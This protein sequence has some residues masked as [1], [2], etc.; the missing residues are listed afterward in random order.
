MMSL[1]T[2]MILLTELADLSRFSFLD[3][4]ASYAGLVSDIRSS[5]ET[6]YGKGRVDTAPFF[7]SDSE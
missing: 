3:K 4:L 5:G 1:L 6:E 7:H 2:A